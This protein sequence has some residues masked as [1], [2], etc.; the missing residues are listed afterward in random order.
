MVYRQQMWV[1]GGWSNNPSTNWGDAW[2]SADG[3]TWREFKTDIV[4]KAR[5][6]HSALV[7]QDKLW[8]AGGHARPLS[9]E[10]WSLHLPANWPDEP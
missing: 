4:W 9:S 5:H 6:E 8:V 10:V 1:L 2:Y 7:H 3:R